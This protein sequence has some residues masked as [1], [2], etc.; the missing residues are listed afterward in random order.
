MLND[1]S[2]NI[3]SLGGAGGRLHTEGPC[4][5]ASPFKPVSVFLASPSVAPLYRV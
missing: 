3:N 2:D 5:S 1:A 4:F